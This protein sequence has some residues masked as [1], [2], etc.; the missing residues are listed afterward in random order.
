MSMSARLWIPVT[1]SSLTAYCPQVSPATSTQDRRPGKKEFFLSL[2]LS[3][4]DLRSAEARPGSSAT[5]ADNSSEKPAAVS[6]ADSDGVVVAAATDSDLKLKPHESNGEPSA[7]AASISNPQSSRRK[8]ISRS[9]SKT[10][11]DALRIPSSSTTPEPKIPEARRSSRLKNATKQQEVCVTR[12]L[13]VKA[14][15]IQSPPEGAASAASVEVLGD[16]A[17][18]SIANTVDPHTHIVKHPFLR[19]E[20]PMTLQN[21][22][23]LVKASSSL[24]QA[25]DADDDEGVLLD[26]R[27]P[28]EASADGGRKRKVEDEGEKD[29]RQ[30]KK[31]ARKP[32][33]KRRKY[34]RRK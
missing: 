16:V 14:V 13:K 7:D 18:R 23:E 15:V 1:R 30:T 28:I 29:M 6:S 4:E 12:H 11:N 8:A 33:G 34:T 31:P 32:T 27:S 2:R 9:L 26:G 17:E 19:D 22:R 3:S 25:K 5:I 10:K 20:P 24:E 21:L